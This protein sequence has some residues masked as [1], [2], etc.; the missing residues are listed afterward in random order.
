M[1]HYQSKPKNTFTF[2][3]QDCC[4]EMLVVDKYT[5]HSN[6][7]LLQ[8][9]IGNLAMRYRFVISVQDRPQCVDGVLS[10]S[11]IQHL[12]NK[13]KQFEAIAQMIRVCRKKGRILIYVWSFENKYMK[14]RLTD[15]SH[16]YLLPWKVHGTI[17]FIPE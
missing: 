4:R 2:I 3:G 12:P 6:L 16:E 7:H 8:S 15:G 5:D 9:D 14:P 11:V 17:S 1:T 10:I 13:Y